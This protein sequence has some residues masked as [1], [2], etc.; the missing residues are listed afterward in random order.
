MPRRSSGKPWLHEHS[1]YWCS[2][3]DGNRVYLDKDYKAAC[4][5]LKQQLT[6]KKRIEQG[7]T[8]EWLD[9][10][11]AVL[12]DEF[13]DDIQA[14]KKPGT[15]EGYRYRLLRALKIIG[16][17]TRVAD[18]GKLHLAKIERR[19]SGNYSPTTIKDTIASL[20]AVFSWAVKHD[21]LIENPLIAYVKPAARARTRTISDSEFDLLL[22]HSDSSFQDVLVAMRWTGCRP[23]EIR[24]LIWDWVD[25]EREL[26]ILPDH[27]TITRQRNP[28][29]RT[30]PLAPAVMEICVRLVQQRQEPT[31]H[32]FL[33]PRGNPY[34]K[35]ALCRKMSR[36]RK[37]AGIS[38]KAGEE[39]VLYCNRHTFGSQASGRVSDIELATLIG[40]T[41]VRTTQRYVHINTDRLR[42]IQRRAMGP[43]QESA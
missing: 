27:K 31:D 6:E 13:L 10:S 23:V 2:T 18:I 9:A 32:V 33:N 7:A 36:L 34:T 28:L 12:A 17:K 16:P 21:L 39:L 20:Q 43:T 38:S 24:T 29:P 19:M 4:R 40:H 15:H 37:R 14:R 26:W 22:E 5:K 41:D 25:L 3:I 1:G 35:D 11:I 42:D 8:V 30:I